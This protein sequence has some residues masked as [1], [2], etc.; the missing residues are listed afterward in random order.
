MRVLVTGG[1][2]FLGSH[3]VPALLERG[4]EVIVQDIL[5]PELAV[6]IKEW[7]PQVEYRW[8]G[9]VDTDAASLKGVDMVV[10]LA[11][12]GDVPLANSSPRYTYQ[13][14]TDAMLSLLTTLKETKTPM[15]AMSTENVY[16]RVPD[17]RLPA[18]EDEP[19]RPKNGYAAS[20]VAMEALCHA[21]A[22][23]YEVPIGI[24]RSSS[25]F[26]E[27]SRPRQVVAIFMRQAIKG[28]PITLEGDGYQTRDFNYVG[29]MVQAILKVASRLA[30]SPKEYDVWNVGSGEETSLKQLV[31][32]IID[33]TG[34]SSKAVNKPGRPGEEGRLCISIEK[35][36]RELGYVPAIGLRE[37]LKR[38]ADWE[39]SSGL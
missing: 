28:E 22:Y 6:K 37:G 11:T 25:L 20:K 33:V 31:E 16:G 36:R 15:L 12:Q 39:V 21:Y 9:V 35:A 2:G 24:I 3:L 5:A 26:G 34:S 32:T 27:R 19:S 4:D 38:A 30:K 13:L 1:A 8:K 17:D 10:H 29:N 23:Q 7:I 14:N 18:K